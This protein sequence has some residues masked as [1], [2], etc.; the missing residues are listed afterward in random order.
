MERMMHMI[1]VKYLSPTDTQKGKLVASVMSQPHW[2]TLTIYYDYERSREGQERDQFKEAA[3]RF[4][5]K[6][7]WDCE[8]S[9]RGRLGEQNEGFTLNRKTEN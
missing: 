2:G 5:Q 7:M 3:E 4:I 1:S 9:G 6:L 8:I